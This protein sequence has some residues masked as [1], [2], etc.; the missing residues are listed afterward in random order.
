LFSAP[1]M[2]YQPYHSSIKTR[3]PSQIPTCR[4]NGRF[5]TISFTRKVKKA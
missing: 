1:R 4:N 5:M 2:L 3:H